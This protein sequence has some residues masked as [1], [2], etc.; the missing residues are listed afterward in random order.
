MRNRCPGSISA[1][2][3][4]SV[5]MF[6]RTTPGLKPKSP[7]RL[8]LDQQHLSPAPRP[9]VSATLEASIRN[10]PYLG[11]LQHRTSPGSRNKQSCNCSHGLISSYAAGLGCRKT[12]V[13]AIVLAVE[14]NLAD[15]LIGCTA[16]RF[17]V[18]S[19]RRDSEYTTT[20]CI[21]CYPL[22]PL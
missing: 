22:W 18:C 1:R 9:G 13:M 5:V 8:A 4:P 14:V 3:I 7:K 2:R 16:G 10:G 21:V 19:S 12:N 15:G 6:S 20:T 11:L 17:E